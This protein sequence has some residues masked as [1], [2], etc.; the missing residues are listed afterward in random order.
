VSVSPPY[1]LVGVGHDVSVFGEAVLVSRSDGG[2]AP[3]YQAA[4]PRAPL[5]NP[6]PEAAI[7]YQGITAPGYVDV[8]LAATGPLSGGDL[9][10]TIVK[11]TQTRQWVNGQWQYQ[12]GSSCTYLDLDLAKLSCDDASVDSRRGFGQPNLAGEFPGDPNAPARPIKFGAWNYRGGLFLGNMPA[13]TGDQS[14]T[15]RIQ[16]YVPSG[17]QG[18]IRLATLSLYDFG[19]PASAYG[20]NLGV[21]LPSSTDPNLNVGEGAVTWDSKWGS[22]LP[23]DTASSPPDHTQDPLQTLT[24]S[25]A[26]GAYRS[27]PLQATDSLPPTMALSRICLAL[28]DEDPATGPYWRYFGSKEYGPGFSTFPANDSAPRVWR[29]GEQSVLTW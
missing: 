4:V 13:A 23:R 8:G 17:G 26:G 21:F 1:E 29:L 16:L 12:D 19:S 5:P 10:M 22:I 9:R 14:G 27:L 6:S 20:V 3:V 28:T 11:K 18:T 24:L 2:P 25:G 7:T 15:A